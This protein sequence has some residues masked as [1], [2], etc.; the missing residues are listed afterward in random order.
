MRQIKELILNE[1]DTGINLLGHSGWN[2]LH[3]ACFLGYQ[4]IVVE[5]LHAG[6]KI[7]KKTHDEFWAPLHLAS[8]KGHTEGKMYSL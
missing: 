8:H 2:A 6:A 5:L 1:G 7:N 4:E 3:Y